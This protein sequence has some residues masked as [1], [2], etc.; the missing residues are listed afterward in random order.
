MTS[1]GKGRGRNVLPGTPLR[2]CAVSPIHEVL[3][4]T[5]NGFGRP[6]RSVGRRPAGS[7][8]SGRVD[9]PHEST[10]HKEREEERESDWIGLSLAIGSPAVDILSAN[11][12]KRNGDQG[13]VRCRVQS[14]VT[15]NQ[16]SDTVCQSLSGRYSFFS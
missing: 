10:C 5:W 11:P 13:G 3:T 6:M 14:I 7:S 9:E 1:Y 12:Y 16:N 8:V 15:A 4:A 2:A